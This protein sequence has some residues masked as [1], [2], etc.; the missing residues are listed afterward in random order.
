MQNVKFKFKTF[1]NKFVS[2]PKN[3]VT[4]TKTY[5]NTKANQM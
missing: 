1:N 3:Y 2:K 4:K 5:K